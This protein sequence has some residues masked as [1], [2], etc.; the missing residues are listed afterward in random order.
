MHELG[1]KGTINSAENESTRLVAI[2]WIHSIFL[3][4]FL[5][6]HDSNHLIH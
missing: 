2:F 3:F 5:D 4:H 1:G 6:V